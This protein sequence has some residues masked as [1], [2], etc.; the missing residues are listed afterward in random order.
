MLR[1]IGIAALFIVASTSFAQSD[2]PRTAPA[3]ELLDPNPAPSTIKVT[4]P[5]LKD[6]VIDNASLFKGFGCTGENKSLPIKWENAPKD[7]KSF[8]VIIHDPDAP[9]GAGFF[10][11]SVFNLPPTTTSLDR[12]ANDKLPAGA[13]QG[14]TDFGMSSYGGPC[15]PPGP[16]HRYIATV[17]ALKVPKLELDSKATAALLRFMLRDQTIALGRA[18]ATYGRAK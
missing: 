5:G 10:H 18:S 1:S 17:Y 15:P 14:Y 16:A 9:T 2:I 4:F 8:A 11:W 12:G 3:P 7:A 13:V 6:N